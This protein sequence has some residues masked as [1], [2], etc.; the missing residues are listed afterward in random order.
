MPEPGVSDTRIAILDAAEQ[1][2]ADRG[3]HG[4]TLRAIAG[5]GGVNLSLINYH[6]GNKEQL[7]TATVERRY[8]ELFARVSAGVAAAESLPGASGS[9]IMR[10]F[11]APILQLASTE[12]AQWRHYLVLLAEGMSV[13][14]VPGIHASL[15]RLASVGSLLGDAMK[16][17]AGGGGDTLRLDIANYLV[18]AAIIY[19]TKDRGLLDAKTQG[20]RQAARVDRILDEMV[21]F[22]SAGYAALASSA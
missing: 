19:I 13:Y 22:F 6:F 20:R 15:T 8:D 2:F 10:G 4:A 5:A 16:R 7:F 11:L 1:V 18:E 17:L 9:G 14:D 21:V 12:G 3:F